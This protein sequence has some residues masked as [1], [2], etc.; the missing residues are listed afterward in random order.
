PPLTTVPLAEGV[1]SV[2]VSRSARNRLA[3]VTAA[4]ADLGI[5]QTAVDDLADLERVLT[6]AR[7]AFALIAGDGD[8]AVRA[9]LTAQ[10]LAGPIARVGAGRRCDDRGIE[11]ELNR[12]VLD[13]LAE[14][15]YVDGDHAAERLH[16]EGFDETRVVRTGSTLADS[17]TVRR[18]GG[19]A[20]LGDLRL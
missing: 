9:A 17:P 13:E 1:V 3:S 6:D 19:F 20:E 14:R 15:L 7:P 11:G 12:I 2:G 10:R 18:P 8:A 5:P 16:A 4:L